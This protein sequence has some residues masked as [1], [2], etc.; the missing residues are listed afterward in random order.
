MRNYLTTAATVLSIF[1]VVALMLLG[2]K[3]FFLTSEKPLVTSV[4]ETP[5]G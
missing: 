1:A 4:D 5:A 2:P 3:G